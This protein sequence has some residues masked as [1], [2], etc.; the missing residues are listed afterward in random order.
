MKSTILRLAL[1]IGSTAVFVLLAELIYRAVATGMAGEGDLHL[2]YTV[3]YEDDDGH[4]YRDQAEGAQ[5]G[6]VV[7]E[8]SG[9]RPTFRFAP[10]VRFYICY[11]GL[12]H[13]A[14]GAEFDRTGN[15]DSLCVACQTNS[16]GMREREEVCGP[17][18][19]GERRILCVGDSFTFG[20]GVRVERAWPRLVEGML[21]RDVD[22]GV[23]TVNAGAA[24]TMFVDEYR[25]ALEKRFYV[26][27]PDIVLVTL[28]LND[29]L[30]TSHALAHQ[31][32]TPWLIRHSMLARALLQR[33]AMQSALTIDPD[34]DLVQELLDIPAD[35]P[36]YQAV[37]WL[38][39]NRVG[40]AELWPGG[41]PQRELRAMRDWC[42]ERGVTFAVAIWPHFQGLGPD[43]HYPFE[44][45][46]RLAGAFCAAESIPFLDLLP[47]FQGAAPTEEL[48]V[49]PADYHGNQRAQALA[50]PAIATFLARLLRS[51]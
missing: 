44:K 39:G 13:A 9:P 1:L 47:S 37:T 18:P 10:D 19:P 28:C 33:Y 6:L 5:A 30:P 14:R 51:E 26:V 8:L 40:R 7:P 15:D 25:A 46:H 49:S 11:R 3:H 41:G 21:R 29:L 23:R 22:D 48:W 35:S 16:L 34:R 12:D 31:R 38:Q 24:G 36:W 27:Q 4:V 42:R 32:P 17:K 43:E 50:A 20:W 2:R 45:I